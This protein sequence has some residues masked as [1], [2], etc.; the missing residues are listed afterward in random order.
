MHLDNGA[1]VGRPLL[2]LG[3]VGPAVLENRLVVVHVRDEDDHHG[4][5]GVDCLGVGGLPVLHAALAVVHGGDVELV[6]VPLQV[7]VAAH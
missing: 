7:D 2:N 5:G 1:A 4:G 3:R 6:L